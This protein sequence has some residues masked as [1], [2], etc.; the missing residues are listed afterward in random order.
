MAA[1]LGGAALV[2]FV[3]T[4]DMERAERFFGE[5]L[6]LELLESSPYVAVYDAAGTKVRVTLVEGFVPQPFTV[7]GWEVPGL[8]AAVA[9]LVERGVRFERFE[10]MDQDEAGIWTAPGGDRVA[11]FKDPNG[12]MLSLTEPS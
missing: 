9:E 12:N 10:G 5:V 4:T 11:W 6:G 1:S 2:G 3:P 8:G 7:L